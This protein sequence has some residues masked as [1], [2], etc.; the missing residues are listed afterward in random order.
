[1][2]VDIAT[3]TTGHHDV[4]M[5]RTPSIVAGCAIFAVISVAEGSTGFVVIVGRY[6][7]VWMYDG[8]SRYG[9]NK[10]EVAAALTS[11]S[12]VVPVRLMPPLW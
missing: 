12:L 8:N 1:M 2:V 10:S 5:A 4:W 9:M 7:I 11:K 3:C 6:I